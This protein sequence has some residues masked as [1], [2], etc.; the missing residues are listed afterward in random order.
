[1]NTIPLQNLIFIEIESGVM[2][3]LMKCIS[4][5]SSVI[6]TFL[7]NDLGCLLDP[8]KLDNEFISE[9]LNN[10]VASDIGPENIGALELAYTKI[11]NTNS[12]LASL[13]VNLETHHF[14]YFINKNKSFL[15]MLYAHTFAQSS[16]HLDNY[17]LTRLRCKLYFFSYEGL[18]RFSSNMSHHP[19]PET[20]D[21][22]RP[23]I[24]PLLLKLYDLC[25]SFDDTGLQD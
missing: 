5:L 2:L 24:W 18:I 12:S 9:I 20:T 3:L 6:E 1:M 23:S 21:D 8:L 15:D 19:Y 25:L 10:T 11:K 7:K 4:K 17:Q 14:H 13:I 22:P 16:I